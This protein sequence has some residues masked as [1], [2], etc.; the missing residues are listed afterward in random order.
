MSQG[1]G[2]HAL[3]LLTRDRNADQCRRRKFTQVFDHPNAASHALGTYNGW[4][5]EHAGSKNGRCHAIMTHCDAE[6][7]VRCG[8]MTA[9]MRI[10]LAMLGTRPAASLVFLSPMYYLPLLCLCLFDTSHRL[11]L[12]CSAK[13]MTA[14]N[15]IRESQA[16]RHAI[17]DVS[18]P[19][20]ASE[21][22]IDAQA[23]GVHGL[24]DEREKAMYQ[25]SNHVAGGQPPRHSARGPSP[26][27]EPRIRRAIA[28][29]TFQLFA[30]RCLVRR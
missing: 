12:A 25:L 11:L 13:T 3:P 7:H 24:G 30:S 15:T 27:A 21:A 28:F 17:G 8:N 20:L 2:R 19:R 26:P 22:A 23:I 4:L 18:H 29:S 6:S 1:V 10:P 16:S 9:C 14:S 5:V